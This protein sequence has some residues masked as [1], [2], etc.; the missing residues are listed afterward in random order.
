VPRP[1]LLAPQ[2]Q[3]AGDLQRGEP[4]VI[5][6]L[7]GL[8]DFFPKLMAANLTKLGYQ[9]RAEFMPPTVITE[10]RDF[11][12]VHLAEA[13][14]NPAT[15]ARL[16]TSLKKVT[17]PGERVGVPAIL[18]LHRHGEVW[19]QLQEQLGA[20]VFEIPTLPPSVPGIRLFNALQD[21]LRQ[22]GVR[23]EIGMEAIGFE[24][25]ARQIRWVTTATSAR[26][27]KQSADYFLLATGGILGGGFNSDH[28]GRFWEVIFNLPLTVP[29]DR[30]RWFRQQ[31]LHPDGQ[32]VFAG[33][34]PVNAKLQPV[35]QNGEAMYSNLWVAGG[36]LAHADPI[37]ER[38][39]EG[40]AIATGMAAAQA[41]INTRD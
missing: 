25:E 11:N 1:T 20:S 2:A 9:A 7:Q 28:R 18:G 38:S 4:M 31:F 19:A 16:A 10:R 13:I 34:I 35:D 36:A 12:T 6:G 22:L 17:Q 15:A 21:R 32:P 26:P 30:A 33:G 8:R 5:V 27:L 41:V 37:R 40:L 39:L 14:D 24:A 23:V 29:Q 3:Q